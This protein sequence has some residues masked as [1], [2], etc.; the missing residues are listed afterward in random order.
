MAYIEEDDKLNEQNQT[1]VAGSS[2]PSIVNQGSNAVGTGVSTA[3]IGAGGT[4]KWTNIQAYLNANK[5]DSGATDLVNNSINPEFDSEKSKIQGESSKLKSDA[6]NSLKPINDVKDNADKLLNQGASAYNYDGN[7][8]DAYSNVTNQF[9]NALGAKYSGPNSY[10]YGLGQK[11]QQF[12]SALGSD[13]G[14]NQYLGDLYQNKAGGQLSSGGRELQKQ[15]NISNEPLAQARKNLL[16]KYSQLGAYRDQTAKD[17]NDYLANTAQSFR[18][19]QN[20]IKDY[21][22]NSSNSTESGVSKAESDARYGYDQTMT[23]KEGMAAGLE[24]ISNWKQLQDY[25]APKGQAMFT[26]D[27]LKDANFRNSLST[28]SIGGPSQQA[29]YDIDKY[30]FDDLTK[31]QS[32]QD[33]KYANTGDSDKRKFNMI[34]DIL[35]TGKKKN[36]GFQVRG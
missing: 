28:N 2:G 18:T 26:N 22:G 20:Q 27:Q 15:L 21:L 36:A 35:G 8:T 16:D 24:G 34:Q 19:G 6:D 23:G 17:T 33:A 11:A 9:K 12:G 29:L 14:F 10:F 31:F 32:A 13:E 3:G 4:G 25:Y 30:G 7:Q 1:Q 5:G